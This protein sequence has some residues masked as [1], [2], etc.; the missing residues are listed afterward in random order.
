MSKQIVSVDEVKKALN[1]DS[2]RNLSKDKI[3]EFVSL[4]PS[5]DK[6]VAI[7]IINQFPVYGELATK[8]VAELTD[9]CNNA[10]KENSLSQKES[11]EAYK[12]VL[13]QLGELLKKDAISA[14]E[15]SDITNKM[16]MIA[17][18][19]AAKDS[20]NKEFLGNIIKYGGSVIGG[21]LFLGAII[22]GVN[23]KGKSIPKLK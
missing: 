21:A 11:I 16:I 20:E 5:M 9:L 12:I 17:D 15:R 14:E 7:S 23:A 18:K 19:I 10:L 13:S 4:I 2:F 1:I 6:E 22:L 3:I 8:M